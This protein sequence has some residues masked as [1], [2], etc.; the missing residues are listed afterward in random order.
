MVTNTFTPFIQIDPALE[1][2][3]SLPYTNKIKIAQFTPY[4]IYAKLSSVKFIN[5]YSLNVDSYLQKFIS[6]SDNSNLLKNNHICELLSLIL[7]VKFTNNGWSFYQKSQIIDYLKN[8]FS[9]L[10]NNATISQTKENE[11]ALAKVKRICLEYIIYALSAINIYQS[12]SL[13]PDFVDIIAKILQLH[14]GSQYFLHTNSNDLISSIMSLLS[15]NLIAGQNEALGDKRKIYLFNSLLSSIE[16]LQLIALDNIL[17]SQ[18]LHI[19]S[20]LISL[21]LTVFSNLPSEIQANPTFSINDET[22]NV[23]L[24]INKNFSTNGG[25]INPVS[26]V[27]SSENDT[28]KTNLLSINVTASSSYLTFY[29]IAISILNGE[30]IN[31]YNNGDLF[32]IALSGGV[33]LHN[34]SKNI[35]RVYSNAL[36]NFSIYYDLPPEQSNDTGMKIFPT[37]KKIAN[38]L[39]NPQITFQKDLVNLPSE[40]LDEIRKKNASSVVYSYCYCQSQDSIEEG[41][42]SSKKGKIYI[43]FIIK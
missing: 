42:N 19:E 23:S 41:K 10:I 15:D 26:G 37:L 36:L 8:F 11:A 33:A 12:L 17:P 18:E 5:I 30:V 1:V 31:T 21:H 20:K 25:I 16:Y 27:R 14:H 35:P 24:T 43:F 38:S 4:A 28:T 32:D 40:V 22:K 9:F 29:G 6:I 13:L 2:E 34:S 3:L 7:H 39:F